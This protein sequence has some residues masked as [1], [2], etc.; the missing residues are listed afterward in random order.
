MEEIESLIAPQISLYATTGDYNYATWEPVIIGATPFKTV[1]CFEVIEHI[2]NPMLFL[3]RLKDFIADD[4]DIYISFPSGRPQFLW[5]AGHFHEY[6]K[7]RA[8]KLFEMAGYQIIRSERS[9][10]I[11]KKPGDYFKGFRPLLRLIF[12]LRCLLY[13]LKPKFYGTP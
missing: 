2:L 5:T 11:W 12:P 13:H 6:S 10:I 8:E 4:A 7:D 1:F 9:S 3:N